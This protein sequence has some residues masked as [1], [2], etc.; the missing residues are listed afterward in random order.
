MIRAMLLVTRLVG[1]H[2]M[3]KNREKAKKPKALEAHVRR[4]D[5]PNWRFSTEMEFMMSMA[6]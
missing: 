1:Y 4:M 2:I 3:L 6:R 5:V